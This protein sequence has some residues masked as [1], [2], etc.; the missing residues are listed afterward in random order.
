MA[1][2]IAFWSLE[3]GS[4]VG[5]DVLAGVG[6]SELSFLLPRYGTAEGETYSTEPHSLVTFK[7]GATVLKLP[8]VSKPVGLVQLGTDNKKGGNSEGSDLTITGYRPGPFEVV[9]EIWTQ[10]Q[11]DVL[12]D[13]VSKLWA[14]PTKRTKLSRIAVDIDHPECQRLNVHSVGIMGLSF[15]E[16][17]RAP[18]SRIYR[19][20]VIESVPRTKKDP[21]TTIGKNG[22]GV[23]QKLALTEAQKAGFKNARPP[24]PSENLRPGG[25]PP[26]PAGGAE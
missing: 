14:I 7:A 15:G 5:R 16:D 10:P 22:P 1:G 4:T 8:G 17:G 23:V 2:K 26:P 19:F 25:P 3:A 6:E 12:C 21:T 24:R 9:C 20:K 18:G 11:W 13:V